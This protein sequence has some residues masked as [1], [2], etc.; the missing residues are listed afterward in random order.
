MKTLTINETEELKNFIKDYFQDDLEI[1]K[2]YNDD[3]ELTIYYNTN[4]NDTESI[5]N[6]LYSN[7]SRKFDGIKSYIG[8]VHYNK[9]FNQY[10]V[11]KIKTRY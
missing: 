4:Y 11:F 5:T 6:L 8:D 7:I 10:I 1:L 2:P 9:L 3:K